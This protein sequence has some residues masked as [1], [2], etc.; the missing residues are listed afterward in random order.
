MLLLL[1]LLAEMAKVARRKPAP[2]YAER[3]YDTVSRA[4]PTPLERVLYAKV[5]HAAGYNTGVIKQWLC[6][7]GSNLAHVLGILVVALPP[8][9]L[10]SLL[11][12]D[13]LQVLARRPMSVRLAARLVAWL[14]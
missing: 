12:A 7:D 6:L 3:V 2:V 1:L 10:S 14:R 13:V 8:S 11:A 5:R 9:C 4:T